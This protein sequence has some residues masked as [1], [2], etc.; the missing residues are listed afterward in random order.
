MGNTAKAQS[1]FEYILL[2]AGV[3]VV[4]IV[5]LSPNGLFRNTIERTLNQTVNQINDMV[6]AIN[7]Q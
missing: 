3:V 7:L 4:L 6:N 2:V 5:F 1:T